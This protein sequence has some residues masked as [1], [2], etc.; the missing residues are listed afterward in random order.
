M[1]RYAFM[2]YLNNSRG[3]TFI[4][5]LIVLAILIIIFPLIISMGVTLDT[6]SSY[7]ELSVQ[8]FFYFFR[9]ELIEAKDYEVNQDQVIVH[10]RDGRRAIF[11]QYQ[12][13]VVRR[14]DGGYEVYLRDIVTISFTQLSIGIKATVTSTEGRDYEKTIIFYE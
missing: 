5:M 4:S 6:S 8:Q 9:D 11:E 3:Y 7:A 10:L 12:H 1:R 13:S 2:E 14:I